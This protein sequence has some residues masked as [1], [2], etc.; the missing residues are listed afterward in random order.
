MFYKIISKK[1][2]IKC[3]IILGGLSVITSITWIISALIYQTYMPNKIY[4]LILSY[5]LGSVYR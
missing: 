2:N 1:F 3:F 5:L 4:L